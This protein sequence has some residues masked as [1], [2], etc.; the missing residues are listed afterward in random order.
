M[1]IMADLLLLKKQ[2]QKNQP[3]LLKQL[4]KEVKKTRCEVENNLSKISCER[5]RFYL[6]FNK[7]YFM[8][9]KNDAPGMKGNRSRNQNGELRDKRNDTHLFDWENL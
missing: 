4:R 5:Q 3:I 1:Q 2:G 9:A 8:S 7:L 6:K